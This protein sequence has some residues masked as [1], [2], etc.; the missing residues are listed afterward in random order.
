MDHEL[1]LMVC[2]GGTRQIAEIH[3]LS[4]VVVRPYYSTSGPYDAIAKDSFLY[5]ADY[6]A[7][8]ITRG[9]ISVM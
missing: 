1:A 8:R 5:V 6:L 4:G 2:Q 7:G 3:P 9:T